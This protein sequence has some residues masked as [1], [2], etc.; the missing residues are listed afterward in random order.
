MNALSPETVGDYLVAR[1]LIPAPEPLDVTELSGG[2]SGVVLAVR[3]DGS[4]L[5]VKQA[6]ERF[7]VADEWLV[8]PA[9]ALSEAAALELMAQRAPGS[10]P[11]LL[12]VDPE[13]FVLVMEEAPPGWRP[14]KAALLDGKADP[15]V[16]ARLGRLLAVVHSADADLGSADSFDAQRVD[17]YLRTIQRRH[18]AL[19]AEIGAY[20]ERLLATRRCLVH[21]DWSPKNV[22]AGDDGLWVVDWEV[23]HRGDPV[24]DLAFLLNHLLLKTIHRPRAGRDYEACGRAFLEAYAHDVDLAYLLGLAGCLM[25][26]RVD[27]KSPAEYLTEPE[28]EQA[29]A[30]GIAMLRSPP[31]SLA[32]AW[33]TVGRDPRP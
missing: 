20:V 17:P 33:R 30:A 21:G 3:S 23:V 12:D 28:R 29:R 27:G 22:L 31:E 18:P 8:P 7:R 2:I 25:L 11:T 1:G 9:R 13:A 26:A 32:G 16:A 15:N 14:W 10:V 19:A 24:F 5:V 4:H 6:L